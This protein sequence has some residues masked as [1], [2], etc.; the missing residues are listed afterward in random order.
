MALDD[1]IEPE[2]AIAVAIT[3][4]IASPPVRKV[5]RK[6]A[7]Y[8]LAGLMVAKDRLTQ[9]AG[10][11]ARGAVID[12]GGAEVVFSGGVASAAA[13]GSGGEE[14]A[15]AGG[16]SFKDQ[17]SS[18]GFLD[19]FGVATSATL[20]SSGSA[21]VARGLARCCGIGRLSAGS[22]RTGVGSGSISPVSVS[23]RTAPGML[24]TSLSSRY[25]MSASTSG[26]TG[27]S[28]SLQGLVVT[29][30]WRREKSRIVCRSPR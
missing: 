7:V 19:D 14:L 12:S 24:S 15:F 10:G 21:A 20:F 16:S 18:G 26:A 4:A 17:V 9:A 13:I 28:T 6:G 29:Q 27:F 25:R 11:V 5:M 3:A 8:G 22:G 23:T 2:I 30:P 1:Y